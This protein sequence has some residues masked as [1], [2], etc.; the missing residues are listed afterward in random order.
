MDK[1][2]SENLAA[3]YKKGFFRCPRCDKPCEI[4]D[5]NVNSYRIGIECSRCKF[6]GKSFFYYGAEEFKENF[7]GI[8]PALNKIRNGAVGF[9]FDD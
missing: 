7:K 8:I 6:D 3:L 2:F 5:S 9:Y 4:K 1:E